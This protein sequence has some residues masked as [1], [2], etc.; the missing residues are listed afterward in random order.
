MDAGLGPQP[1]HGHLTLAQGTEHARCEWVDHPL[2]IESPGLDLSACCL[3]G[4]FFTLQATG[5]GGR[6]YTGAGEE[7]HGS[8]R[9]T[10]AMA[11]YPSHAIPTPRG[12][13]GLEIIV[14][15]PGAPTHLVRIL[16]EIPGQHDLL[17]GMQPSSVGSPEVG[18]V[19]ASPHPVAG[20]IESA[21]AEL[22]SALA[23][24][25]Q[26]MQDRKKKPR[27]IEAFRS[28]VERAMREHGWA[29]LGEYTFENITRWLG[30][31]SE[32][33]HGWKGVTYN[34]NLSVF[35]SFGTFL[36]TSGRLDRNPLE[37]A[38]PAQ[39]DGEDGS[40][41][42]T[43]ED[44]RAIIFQA[45]LKDRTD[46]RSK[47]NRALY[48]LCLAAHGCR[49]SEPG[50]WRRRHLI[51]DHD[52]P[53]VW[54]TKDLNKNHKQYELALAPELAGLLRAH[55]AQIDR[56][57]AEA[58]LPPAGPD[59]AVFPVVPFKGTF[60]QDRDRAG[61]PAMDYR[62]RPFTPRSFR[63]FFST[64][65]TALGVPEKMVDRLMRHKG[66]TEHRYYDPPL[67]EQRKAVERL[68]RLWPEPGTPVRGCGQNVDNSGNSKCDLTTGGD[69]PED[70]HGS[71]ATQ[72]QHAS[73]RSRA[74]SLPLDCQEKRHDSAR[75]H[76][77]AALRAAL[78]GRRESGPRDA[79]RPILNPETTFSGFKMR[80]DATEAVADLLDALSRLLRNGVGHDGRGESTPH[81]AG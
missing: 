64:Q 19:F 62:Q 9:G 8:A 32:G 23:A 58:K 26:Y 73:T 71:R 29:T 6:S 52:V 72:S 77:D 49:Q 80:E 41:A 27:S 74:A 39:D 14:R 57:R 76:V 45:W 17:P 28:V 20:R 70:G 69:V 33:E 12:G 47:G 21:P 1:S 7:A 2:R 68:P 11:R 42:A 59:D 18:A 31:K 48:W 66:R 55:L 35:R 43:L 56:E 79:S 30:E 5:G 10:L 65:L 22:A 54:W 15:E 63:K 36:A 37:R 67:E 16:L 24:W 46:R 53:H 75:D 50:A 4:N 51:L 44:V 13:R 40:R 81:K 38:E 34:R 60:K 61:I 25:L 3:H 78:E